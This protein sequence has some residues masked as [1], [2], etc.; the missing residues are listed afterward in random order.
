MCSNFCEHFGSSL[1][2]IRTSSHEKI[3]RV[4]QFQKISGNPDALAT[5][6]TFA[7]CIFAIELLWLF[8]FIM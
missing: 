5:S 1:V 4:K 7:L 3:K 2:V 6:L 8:K